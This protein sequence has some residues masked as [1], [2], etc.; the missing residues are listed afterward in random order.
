MGSTNAVRHWIETG[1][2]APIR[3]QPRHLP[4]SRV[5]EATGAIKEMYEEGV[6]EPSKSPWCSLIA[7]VHK[8]DGSTRFCVDYRKLNSVTHKDTYPLPRLDSTLDSLSGSSWFSTLDLKSGYWQVE[9]ASDTKEKT[10]FPPC[11]GN[12]R[13][14]HLDCVMPRLPFST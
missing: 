7:L 3:Q 14:C 5:E 9:L 8:K 13:R 1:N 12:S 6:I 10:A 4:L 2:A 11:F